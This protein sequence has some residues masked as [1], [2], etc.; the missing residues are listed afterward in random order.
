[1]NAVPWATVS[2]ADASYTDSEAHG[3]SRPCFSKWLASWP[4]VQVA[5]RTMRSR[6]TSAGLAGFA[7]WA[8][9]DVGF[10]AAAVVGFAAGGAVGFVAPDAAPGDGFAAAGDA[11]VAGFMAAGEAIPAAGDA[12]GCADAGPAA[13][14][15]PPMRHAPN[16]IATS[17]TSSSTGHSTAGLDSRL[18]VGGT[19]Q[20]N[21]T[22]SPPRLRR[23]PPYGQ[24]R[25]LI[26]ATL[27]SS[28]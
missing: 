27:R 23:P 19:I 21:C 10:A 13:C 3:P 14:S 25:T 15:L 12:A 26:P 4:G 18:R 5:S 9:A 1:V 7:A 22:A 20:A 24:R 6:S 28:F 16:A 2:R 17:N 11:A 8:T